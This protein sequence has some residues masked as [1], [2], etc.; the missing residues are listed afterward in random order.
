MPRRTD[1]DEGPSQAD[2]DRFGGETAR[3]RSCGAG[4]YDD[5]EWCHECGAVMHPDTPGPKR[6]VVVT[7]GVVV[8]AF[9]LAHL[10]R[11]F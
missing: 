4:V 10:L 11:I 9:V 6:W 5:A 1:H 7:V 3:C 8:A 2:L